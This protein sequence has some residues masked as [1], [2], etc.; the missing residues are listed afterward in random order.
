MSDDLLEKALVEVRAQ[1]AEVVAKINSVPEDERPYYSALLDGIALAIG[2]MQQVNGDVV[3]VQ[4]MEKLDG[5][6]V[7]VSDGPEK[8]P[9]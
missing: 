1:F 8:A 5:S 9:L 7:Q 4:S 2:A 6:H 3:V